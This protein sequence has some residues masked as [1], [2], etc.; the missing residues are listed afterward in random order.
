MKGEAPLRI[1]P[2]GPAM[3]AG[4]GFEDESLAYERP[5]IS[6]GRKLGSGDT[7]PPPLSE[8]VVC[9]FAVHGQDSEALRFQQASD[10]REPK[11]LAGL[12]QMGEQGDRE[13][14]PEGLIFKRRGRN[15]VADPRLD[16]REAST[17]P[18]DGVGVHVESGDARI[19]RQVELS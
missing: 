6:Q 8:A 12:R 2:G 17:Q 9:S 13:D 14:E 10:F 19:R 1:D 4:L 15:R 11:V 16:L 3:R 7:W 18:C 5:A